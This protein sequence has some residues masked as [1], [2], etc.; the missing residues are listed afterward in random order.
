MHTPS[1]SD[2]CETH[3]QP[4]EKSIASLALRLLTDGGIIGGHRFCMNH[5][6]P[7]AYEAQL[8]LLAFPTNYI[9]T[10]KG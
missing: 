1:T 2:A 3:A 8:F 6:L 7:V 5:W 9:E 10:S 4:V